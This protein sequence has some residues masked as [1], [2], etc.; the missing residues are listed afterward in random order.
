MVEEESLKFS[1][2][3]ISPDSEYMKTIICLADANSKTLGML[4]YGAFDRLA[5]KGF[6]LGCILPGVGCIGYLLYGISRR[7]SRVKLTHLCVDKAWQGKG[8]AKLL[9]QDLKK[10]TDYLYGIL[11]SC[12]RDYNL[13]K[14]WTSL[15]FTSVSER[16]GKSKDGSILTEYWYDYEHLNLLNT[17]A[18]QKT[19]SKL[20]V[21]IDANIFF[22]LVDEENCDE[23]S[24]ES[25]VLSADWLASEI[26]L[27]LTNE[28]YNEIDRNLNSKKREKLRSVIH[29]FTVLPGIQEK[30]DEVCTTIRKFFPKEMKD[31]DSSDLRQIARAI[32]SSIETPF[33]VTRDERLLGI[34]EKI[35]TDFNLLIIHP[36]D[37]IIKLDQLRRETE[38]QPNRLGGTGIQEKRIQSQ[39]IDTIIDL[40]LDYSQSEKKPDFRK[41]IRQLLSIP[42]RFKCF[43]VGRMGEDPIALIAYDSSENEELIVPIFRFRSNKFTP[44]IIRRCIFQCFSSAAREKRQFTRITETYLNDKTIIA[45]EEDRFFKTED[46]WLRANLAISDNALNISVFIDNL[47]KKSVN[48]YEKYLPLIDI[49]ANQNLI[50]KPEIMADIERTLYPAKITDAEIPTYIIPIRPWFAK[51]LFDQE[52]AQE[53]IW[54]AREELALKRE[55]VYYCTKPKISIKS[56]GRILWYVSATGT[57]GKSSYTVDVGAIRACSQLDEIVIGKP[58]DLYKMFRRLGVYNFQDVLR[59]AKNDENKEIMAIKFSDTQLFNNPVLFQDFEKI[60]GRKIRMQTSAKIAAKE[61]ELLYNIGTSNPSQT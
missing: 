43:T 27:C 57:E 6:V 45:L 23:A 16:P 19:E 38:Y 39:E 30:F 55:V 13:H 1:I 33:F 59:T 44:T 5:G 60:L 2:Q 49:L 47:C 18:H 15:G 12:R 36:V 58:K 21:A 46:G 29:N 32:T 22:D 37:F 34:E 9:I 61:F 25:K 7:C 8:V 4:P 10:R 56:P 52:L 53:V 35:Y 14:M 31:S 50:I 3:E 28:I 40:F 51:D 54:G 42:E 41:K 11:A 20:C 26:E 48:G 17:L 24:K